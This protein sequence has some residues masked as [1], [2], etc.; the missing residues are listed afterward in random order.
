MTNFISLTKAC[1][2]LLF[3]GIILLKAMNVTAADKEYL[4]N[5]FVNEKRNIK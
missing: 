3:F 2:L 4:W 5:K 1:Y